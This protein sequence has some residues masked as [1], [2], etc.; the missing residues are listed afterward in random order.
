MHMQ[1]KGTIMESQRMVALAHLKETFELRVNLILSHLIG[2]CLF[3][4]LKVK[5]L[6]LPGQAP[7]KFKVG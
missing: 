1:I 2:A 4:T 7:Y 5:V 6:M 3:P